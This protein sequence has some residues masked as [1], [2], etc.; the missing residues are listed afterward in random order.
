MNASTA[1]E[2]AQDS[3]NDCAAHM[4]QLAAENLM[5][6]RRNRHLLPEYANWCRGRAVGYKVAAISMVR[7]LENIKPLI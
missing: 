2:L 1:F 6:Y 5:D 3:I 7:R 4:R